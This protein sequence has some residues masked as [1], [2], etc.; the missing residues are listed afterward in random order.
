MYMHRTK[1][2]ACHSHMVAASSSS[3]KDEMSLGADQEEAPAPTRD[4]V[5]SSVVSQRRG[6]VPSQR[7]PFTCKYEAHWKDDLSIQVCFG[8]SFF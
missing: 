2:T 4:A 1:S 5:S 3:S 8:F 7:N 6:D